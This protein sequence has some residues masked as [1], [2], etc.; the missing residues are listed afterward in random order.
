MKLKSFGKFHST[1]DYIFWIALILFTN[2]G[3][4]FKALGE[5][6]GSG[7]VNIADFLFI[8]LCVCFLV[9]HKKNDSIVDQPFN[10]ILK[11]FSI[12]LIYYL[13]VFVFFTPVLKNNPL[14]SPVQAY[15]KVRYAIY[16]FSLIF[17]VYRFYLRSY[18]IFLNLFLYSSIIIIILFII[19]IFTGLDILPV[20]LGE[21]RF[22]ATK[23]LFM[24]S[25]GLMYI[26]ITM[27]VVQLVFK[28]RNNKNKLILIA[29][30]LMF[31]I[32][33]LAILR[34]HIIGTFIYFILASFLFNYANRK[35][36]IPIKKIVAVFFY[37]ILL[38]FVLRV[39]FPEY[40]DA[41]ISAIEE[42]VLVIQTG[43][44]SSGRE[45]VRLGLGKSF[46]QN[47]ILNNP[48]FGTGFDNRWRTKAGDD[49]GFEAADYPFLSAI[50]MTGIIG[51]LVFIPIYIVLIRTLIYDIKYLRN[52]VIKQNSIETFLFVTMIIYFL[53]HLIQFMN[54]FFPV[55]VFSHAGHKRWYIYLAIYYASRKIF[56]ELENANS[57]VMKGE[58]SH[59]M[60]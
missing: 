58:H 52:N 40:A 2:P 36:L 16:N 5:N 29:F 33:V 57:R 10:S 26:L 60:Y 32:W 8:V 21:R 19:S 27:G 28:F 49:A 18:K 48:Y 56:Y 9:I 20:V 22:I 31:I 13:I 11:Y 7:G 34:R 55:A 25:Y 45:D 39:S 59:S 38:F 41:T 4:V 23:R 6:S 12:Y 54:W 47:I 46:M 44:T 53:Y 24:E 3:G 42:S 43:K 1:V 37:S 35:T 51:L 17:F 15:V 50:A 30:V 14:Y